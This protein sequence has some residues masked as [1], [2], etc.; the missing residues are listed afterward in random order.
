MGSPRAALGLGPPALP[1]QDDLCCFPCAPVGLPLPA[2]LTPSSSSSVCLSP[3]SA[4]REDAWLSPH[5][6]LPCF[7][8]GRLIRHQGQ[9][10]LPPFT[11]LHLCTELGS[12]AALRG[13]KG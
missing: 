11:D 2:R 3:S 7:S 6:T 12:Q 9:D 13:D 8:A 4:P 1:T 5:P 10:T